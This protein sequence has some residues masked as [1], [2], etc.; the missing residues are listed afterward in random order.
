MRTSPSKQLQKRWL[1]V[2]LILLVISAVL[3]VVVLY[4]PR[5]TI[6][7][8]PAT[9]KRVVSREILLSVN[10]KEPDYKK[11]VLPAKIIDKTVEEVS[12]VTRSQGSL[13]DDYAKGILTLS[14]SQNGEQPLLPKTHLKHEES[15]VFF[16]TD[17]AVRIPPKGQ[18]EVSVTA[19]QPGLSGNIPP[20]RFIVDK[21]PDELKQSVYGESS[22]AF[23]GGQV[24]DNPISESELKEEQKKARLQA[25]SKLQAE[26]SSAAGGAG[27][28][29]ELTSIETELEEITADPGSKVTSYEIRMRLRGRAFVVDNNDLLSLALLGLKSNVNEG[30]EFAAYDPESFQVG[31]NRADFERGEVY[32]ET[33]LE[34]TFSRKTV[35]QALSADNLAGRTEADVKA[36]MSQFENVGDV[37]VDFWPFWVKSIPGR[38]ES[39]KVV[40]E[41]TQ[42]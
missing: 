13:R 24:T 10:N 28:V 12:T 30:E 32:I 14:N 25:E 39:I 36:Y 18:I 41:Q 38:E 40:L 5:A 27:V 3:L 37:N 29:P 8:T 2:L 35:S 11:N 4:L 21:L 31:I 23:T 19:K 9:E 33:A 20:G 6:R 7:I 34:G 16:L 1:R 26:L 42:K 22:M 17:E 15:G